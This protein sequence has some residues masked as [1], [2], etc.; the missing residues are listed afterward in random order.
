MSESDV[1]QLEVVGS[2]RR[3]RVELDEDVSVGELLLQLAPMCEDDL[4]ETLLAELIKTGRVALAGVKGEPLAPATKIAEAGNLD[5]PL[6]I[7]TRE[8]DQHRAD[9][10][11]A[12]AHD[13][14]GGAADRAAAA[15]DASER[16]DDEQPDTAE[17]DTAEPDTAGSS[18]SDDGLRPRELRLPARLSPAARCDAASRALRDRDPVARS[19]V[20]GSAVSPFARARQAW[21]ASDYLRT[22]E[23]EIAEPSL[24]RCV[25][26]PVPSSKGGVGKT[27]LAK[28][29]GTIFAHARRDRC[30][31]LDANPDRGSIAKTFARGHQVYVD[32]L[33][34]EANAGGM[35]PARLDSLLASGPH[36]LKVLAAPPQSERREA[37]TTADYAQVI[38][39]LQAHVGIV[40]I[41]CGTGINQPPV[42][43]ALAAANQLVLVTDAD[44]VAAEM[45]ADALADDIQ[46]ACCAPLTLVGNKMPR[47]KRAGA[48]ARAALSEYFPDARSIVLVDEHKPGAELLKSREFSWEDAPGQWR[49]AARELAWLLAADWPRLGLAPAETTG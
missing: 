13:D 14:D 12:D 20:R 3:V 48:K 31:V 46:K 30:V 2:S 44:W 26:I 45:N 8:R 43:A 5:S 41:D 23:R 32:E 38:E 39:C 24:L 42:Q 28:L 33:L 11:V 29:L 40:V 21:R 7:I 10:E 17:P 19:L 49:H 18:N 37:L 16:A 9:G 36:G 4:D 25:T 27:T 15:L 47:G 1:R 22:L 35:T 6:Q 34:A